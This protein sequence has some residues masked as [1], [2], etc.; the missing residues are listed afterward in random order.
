MTHKY[1]SFTQKIFLGQY[2]YCGALCKLKI[3][4][5]VGIVRHIVY[6]EQKDV[7]DVTTQDIAI[8]NVKLRIGKNTKRL[9]NLLSWR[10]RTVILFQKLRNEQ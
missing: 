2:H 9:V 1:Y 7:R 6:W 5:N 8:A 4:L 10:N 3:K